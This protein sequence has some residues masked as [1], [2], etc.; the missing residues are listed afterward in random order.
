MTNQET[1]LAFIRSI[2]SGDANGLGE[3]MSDDHRF[4]DPLGNAVVGKEKM[5]TGWRGYFD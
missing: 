5:I 4:I 2:N 1:V 3:L